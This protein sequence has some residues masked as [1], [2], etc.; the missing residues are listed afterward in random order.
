[1]SYA[2]GSLPLL[3]QDNSS[4][5]VDET[6]KVQSPQYPGTYYPTYDR[7]YQ[8]VQANGVG[9]KRYNLTLISATINSLFK[10]NDAVVHEE[11]IMALITYHWIIDGG[12]ID[13]IPYNGKYHFPS[14]EKYYT[15]FFD[16]FPSILSCIVCEYILEQSQ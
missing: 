7:L 13:E 6:V 15:N 3:P 1:M 2:S 5:N 12:S 10:H 11:E 9:N 8:R 16:N 4:Q 14:T